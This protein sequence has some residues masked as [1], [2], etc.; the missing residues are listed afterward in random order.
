M[1]S[2]LYNAGKS[3]GPSFDFL[4]ISFAIQNTHLVSF[5]KQITI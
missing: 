3:K 2:Y 1:K 5:D 4:K